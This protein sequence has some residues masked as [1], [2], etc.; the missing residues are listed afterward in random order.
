MDMINL[1]LLLDNRKLLTDRLCTEFLLPFPMT[2]FR[3]CLPPSL[4]L[5]TLPLPDKTWI[6]TSTLN[7]PV[8]EGKKLRR[9]RNLPQSEKWA[10]HPETD[11]IGDVTES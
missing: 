5:P 1:R 2:S 4:I 10:L 7:L 3:T 11:S 6:V 9:V 8:G